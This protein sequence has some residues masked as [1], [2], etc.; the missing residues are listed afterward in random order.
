MDVYTIKHGEE[1]V[2]AARHAVELCLMSPNFKTSMLESHLGGFKERHGVIVT[3]Q[4]YPTMTM[5]GSMGFPKPTGAVRHLVI[6]AAVA[7][8]IEDPGYVPVSHM[9]FE[10]IVISVDILSMPEPVK[11]TPDAKKRK[12]KIGRD[13]LMIEY[14]FRTGIL[15]PIVPIEGRWTK[16]Q[17]L[18][19]LCKKAGFDEDAWK[20]SDYSLFRF[21]SQTFRELS[22]RGPTEEIIFE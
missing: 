10:D 8:A 14:G 17:F 1:L 18:E 4:H 11:G 13:G 3:I 21:T 15:L 2:K 9:E 22:P 6:E 7:A 12:I 16:D 5:R 19:A 20:R